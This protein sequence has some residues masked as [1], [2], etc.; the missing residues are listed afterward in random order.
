ML[1]RFISFIA[2]KNLFTKENPV[3]LAV[4]GGIDSV[5]MTELFHQAGFHFSVAHCNFQLRGTDSDSDQEFVQQL[6]KEKGIQI[7]VRKFET[8]K[9][10]KEKKISIQMAARHLRQQ[11]FGEL[12][13]DFGY[14]YYATAHH[15]DDQIE[16]FFLNLV[17][18]S[19]ISG[20]H[21]ILPKQGK[22][23]HPMLFT[24]KSEIEAFAIENNL[25]FRL[26]RSNLGTDYKRNKIRLHLLPVLKTIQPNYDI[27]L[28]ETIGRIRQ[29]E[30]IYRL[31]VNDTTGKIVQ[32]S[33]EHFRIPVK[34][35]LALK[36]LETLL[37]EM[38]KPF[39][40]QYSATK[41][42]IHSLN[43]HSGKIFISPTH[44]LLRD[45]DYLIIQ[46]N[47]PQEDR[48]Q[49]YSIDIHSG[50]IQTPAGIRISIVE[51]TSGF[52]INNDRRFAFVDADTALSPLYIRH[53]KKGDAFYPLGMNGRKRLSDFFTDQK[54]SVFEKAD[55]WLLCSGNDIVW[56]AGHRLD[57]RFKV[58][59]QT[60]NI[61][62]IEI[63]SPSRE[64]KI[65]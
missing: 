47:E 39:N 43:S 8:R 11:W 53:W 27:V 25:K 65:P 60:K 2:E 44:Q 10:A 42:I 28:T 57:D 45:R 37:Y 12:L 17:R 22:L 61:L 36:P 18:G 63:V 32:Y 35:L 58:T 33:G 55:L 38:I 64:T 24:N 56:I 7:H 31:L 13:N 26:D 59:D 41:D 49:S 40:F 1:Q 54:F 29:S 34:D 16:T 19:G 46:Q 23:V 3:V 62:I 21:G 9:I 50:A 4:S 52:R 15:L 6:A 51:R 14:A 48:L 5:V 30:E 20:L